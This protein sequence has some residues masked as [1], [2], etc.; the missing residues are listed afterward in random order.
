MSKNIK[1]HIKLVRVHITCEELWLRMSDICHDRKLSH[2]IFLLL[3][4]FGA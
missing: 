4:W 2:E 3:C 1:L